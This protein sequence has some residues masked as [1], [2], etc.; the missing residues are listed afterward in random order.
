M[1]VAEAL[2]DYVNTVTLGPA[3]KK[4][5]LR[6]SLDRVRK[7]NEVYFVLCAGFVVV[8][9]V[10]AMVLIVRHAGEGSVWAAT[11]VVF[12]ASLAGMVRMM[13]GFWREK[14]TTDMLLEL[15]VLDDAI[16][17]EVSRTLLERLGGSGSEK[18]RGTSRATS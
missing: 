11:S 18:S 16:L 3:N 6:E 15:S 13:L 12:G 7:R 10:V 9:F 17:K 8:M 2:D 5:A 14:V 1:K 4:A